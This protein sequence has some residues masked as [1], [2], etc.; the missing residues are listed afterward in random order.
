MGVLG[1]PQVLK[2]EQHDRHQVSGLRSLDSQS[3]GLRLSPNHVASQVVQRDIAAQLLGRQAHHV[4]D[5]RA[6]IGVALPKA[7]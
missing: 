6:P 7:L 4:Q 5:R 2:D 3:R 1:R